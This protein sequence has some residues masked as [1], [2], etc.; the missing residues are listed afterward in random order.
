[1]D[2][3]RRSLFALLNMSFGFFGIQFGW[4]LQMANMS[5]IYEY[6]GAKESQIPILWLAAP[7]TGLIVQPIVGHLSDRT[8]GRLGRRRPYFLGGTIFAT[9]ALIMMPHSSAVWM[10]AVLLWMLDF[11]VNISMEPF[12]AFVGDLVSDE[13]RAQ[14]FAVQSLLIGMGAVLASSL[15]WMLTNWFGVSAHPLFP[16]AVDT[17]KEQI[18]IVSHATAASAIPDTVRYAFYAGAAVFFASVIWTVI[19]TKEYPPEDMDAFNKMKAEKSGF[20]SHVR[21]LAETFVQMPKTM[22]QLAW[23]QVFTWLGLFCMWIYF[24]VAIARHVF[25]AA[26]QTSALFSEGVQWGGVCFS[27]YNAVCFVF[28]FVLIALSR[29][30]S[31]KLIHMVCLLLGGLALVSVAFIKNKYMLMLPM[32]GVGI[33]WASIVSMPYAMLS[34]ALPPHRMG[35]Y[36]GIFNFFIV[37][38]QIIASL[39]LG[40]VMNR[41]LHGNSLAAVV[42]GGASMVVAALLVLRVRVKRQ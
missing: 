26:D 35:V 16:A 11:S 24:S 30:V 10:A 41:F 8:W 4:G 38:P 17:V 13:Q 42:V 32:A 6:L 21:D 18:G 34:G 1:M 22:R 28:S 29:R 3:P 37:I 23:V 20:M 33:A 12:R 9:I 19:S 15:P 31:A 25:G 39:G 14:G 7:L 2:K 36:M 40:W 5:A 27:M